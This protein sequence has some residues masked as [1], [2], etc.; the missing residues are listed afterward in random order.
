MGSPQVSHSQYSSHSEYSSR[1]HPRRDL[2]LLQPPPATYPPHPRYLPPHPPP[3][4]TPSPPPAA[5]PPG[6]TYAY[7]VRGEGGGRSCAWSDLILVTTDASVPAPVEVPSLLGAQQQG[8]QGTQARPP[9]PN[10]TN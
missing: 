8:V 4:P 1:P 7:R 3:L 5:Y 6:E 10:R 2:G 9:L